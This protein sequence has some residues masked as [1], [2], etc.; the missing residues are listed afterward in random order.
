[1]PT[2][3][4][5]AETQANISV[6]RRINVTLIDQTDQRA[7]KF[8]SEQSRIHLRGGRINQM[9]RVRSCAEFL[10]F[11]SSGLHRNFP[12]GEIMNVRCNIHRADLVP[13]KCFFRY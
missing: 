8:V 9:G 7:L 12:S 10:V 3:L 11:A 6:C 4:I 1:M 5:K 13:G 2:K